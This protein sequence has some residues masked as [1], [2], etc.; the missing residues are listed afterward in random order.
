MDNLIKDIQYAFRML[1]RKPGFTAVAVITLALGI[2]ANSAIFSVVNA[3]ILRPLPFKNPEEMVRLWERRANSGDA[4]L[5][6]SGHEFAAWQQRSKSFAA[7]TLIQPDG[8]TLTGKGD[9][10]TLDTA[11]VSSEFFSVVGVPPLLGRGF[12]SEDDERGGAKVAVLG[13]KLWKQRFGSDPGVIDQSI[14]LNDQGYTVV[15][16]M[17]ALEF[18]PEVLI[19]ID[20]IGEVQKVGKHSHQVFGRLKPGISLAQAQTELAYISEQLAQENPQANIGHSV[21]AVSLHEDLTGGSHLA[22][23]TLFGAVGFVLLIACANVANLLLTRAASR[24]KEMAIRAALGAGRLRLIRQTLTESLLLAALGGG[25]GLLSAF[26]LVDLLSKITAVNLPR[27]EH[28]NID[29][30]VLFVTIGF[31]LLTGLLTGLAP[32]WRNSDKRLSQWMN[33]GTRS[34]ATSGLRRTGSALVVVEVALAVVLLVGGGL[35]LKSFIQLV[36]VDPGFDPHQVLR[37]DLSLPGLR[38]KE[39][40]K[41]RNFYEQFI[42]KLKGLPGVEAVGATTQTP[43]SPGDNWSSFA[44][45]G[46][47]SP[48]P[49]DQQQA[50]TRAVSNDYFS[51]LRI[52]LRKG[53]FFSDSDTR[54]AVPVIRW[55]DRQPYP[56]HYDDPQPAP[57][58][59][60]NETM[61]RLYWPNQD[62]LGSRL[63]I[64]ASPWMTVVGVVGDVKHNSLSVPA[65]PEIY[66]S[67]LQEPQ[68]SLAVMV[69][70][71]GDPLQLAGAVRE[72]LKTLDKDQP[73]TV[74]TMDQILSNSVAGQRFNALLLGVFASVALMLSMIGVFGVI[75]YSVTQRTQEI[76]IRIA[77][78][79]QRSDVFKL[80]IGQGLALTLIGVA[81]GSVAAF[82][83]TR[84]MRNLLYGVSPTDAA[85]FVVVSFVVTVVALFACYLPGRRA[86][87]V[88]PLVALRYE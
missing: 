80:V 7:I 66:L 58:V 72:E 41:Q 70:T 47:P 64:I 81:I 6:L 78:G 57:A 11:R 49:G 24:Q 54:I 29:A 85:T 87:K 23:F 14:T 63:K 12:A 79:A 43:L 39:P 68:E 16:V 40:Q 10:V 86:S 13:E 3:V 9:P 27:L 19:P 67:H 17:P 48:P 69:R 62:P 50:A 20:M 35:M 74:T 46:R 30:R 1:L 34:S 31:S 32:A 51:T 4:N 75:N 53:R 56:A 61:A 71:S 5:P 65:N 59:I 18:M 15:G 26:W 52:P 2:G 60:I 37:L 28:V 21:Q 55:Y 36:Q 44:I 84:L 82:G 88:D 25:L 22:L 83:L 45:D 38:Y 42:S 76:G 77:L 8:L 73:M 33:D